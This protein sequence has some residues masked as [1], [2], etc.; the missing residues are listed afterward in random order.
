MPKRIANDRYA[1]KFK[2]EIIETMQREKLAKL[3]LPVL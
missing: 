3:L 1:D 2:Q